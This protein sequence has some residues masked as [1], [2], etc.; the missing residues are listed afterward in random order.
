MARFYASIQ[1]NR[2]TATRL[3]HQSIEG[4]IRRWHVGCRV[5]II[6]DENG[7]D[8]VTVY[9]TGG[10]LHWTKDEV[11]AQFTNGE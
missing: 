4:N 2:G 10:S 1:G 3:G 9:R 5:H 7:K 8:Q 6:I 11:I